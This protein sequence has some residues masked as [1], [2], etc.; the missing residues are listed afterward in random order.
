MSEQMTYQEMHLI[1]LYDCRHARYPVSGA[2]ITCEMGHKLGNGRVWASRIDNPRDR[3][4]FKVCQGCQNVREFDTPFIFD[5]LTP[6]ENK[7]IKEE[8]K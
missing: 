4:A 6:M 7:S 3:L 8:E 5:D 2:Q 1:S